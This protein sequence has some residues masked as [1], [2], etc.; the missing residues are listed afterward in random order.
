M[1]WNYR[2]SSHIL[3]FNKEIDQCFKNAI[4]LVTR[5]TLLFVLKIIVWYFQIYSS[6]K[7][8]HMVKM[9][10]KAFWEET[11][12]F[13]I[14]KK[15]EKVSQCKINIISRKGKCSESTHPHWKTDSKW[16]KRHGKK[17]SF[18]DWK[19]SFSKRFM[20]AASLSYNEK[21]R[22]MEKIL[23]STHHTIREMY[24]VQNSKC[25]EEILFFN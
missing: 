11:F 13:F 15:C 8:A 19:E 3:F 25:T 14:I 23:K 17:T 4:F 20:T 12:V 7:R 16:K 24:Y 9:W 21:I 1:I 5:K 2:V 6:F 18:W 22:R 10:T